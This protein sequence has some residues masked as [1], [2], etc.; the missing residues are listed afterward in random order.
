[1]LDEI[2]T[3]RRTPIR[4]TGD[5]IGLLS[6]ANTLGGKPN[7]TDRVSRPEQKH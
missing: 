2:R 7:P 4:T 3:R 6:A 1:M 5:L